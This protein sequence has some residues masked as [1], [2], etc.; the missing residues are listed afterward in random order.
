MNKLS[1][2]DTDI[3]ARDLNGCDFKACK[4]QQAYNRNGASCSE[5]AAH[6]NAGQALDFGKPPDV[7]ADLVDK[8]AGWG[9]DEAYGAV[10]QKGCCALMYLMWRSMGSTKAKVLPEPVSA[11]PMQSR[12]DMMTGSVCACS[13]IDDIK[14]P[15][16]T[17][18]LVIQP[19]ADI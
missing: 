19:A 4:H 3:N 1:N 11:M 5:Q 14:A 8:L 12:P 17:L 7:A 16:P 6:H 10:A 2:I 9:H 13:H 15:S 18:R